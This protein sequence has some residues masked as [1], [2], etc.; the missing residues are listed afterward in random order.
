MDVGI[1]DKVF[2][3]N[4]GRVMIIDTAF[5]GISIF[6]FGQ[7]IFLILAVSLAFMLLAWGIFTKRTTLA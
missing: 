4:L 2:P 3:L 6:E 7:Q 5:K 1:I